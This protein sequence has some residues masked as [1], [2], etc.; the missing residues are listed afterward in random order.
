MTRTRF[1]HG[2]ILLG[3]SAILAGC[4]TMSSARSATSRHPPVRAASPTPSRSAP[5]R[6]G[7]PSPSIATTAELPPF[8]T[9]QMITPQ[10]GWVRTTRFNTAGVAVGSTLWR[11]TDGAKTWRR[12]LRA[13]GTV[14]TWVAPTSASAWI[15]RQTQ[16]GHRF[17]VWTTADGGAHWQ[18]VTRSIPWSGSVVTAFLTVS[19]AG[20]ASL[21]ASGPVGTQTGPQ[22]LWLLTDNTVAATPVYTSTNTQFSAASWA[23]PTVGWMIASS[24]LIN[25]T[26]A[27]LFRSPDGGRQWTPVPLPVPARLPSA[28]NGHPQDIP[29]L[30]LNAPPTFLTPTDGYLIASVTDGPVQGPLITSPVLYQ[31]TN[32]ET[33]SPVWLGAPNQSLTQLQWVDPQHAWVMLTSD[34]G[35]QE[36][37]ATSAT[38]GRSWVAASALPDATARPTDDLLA[39]SATAAIVYAVGPHDAL[40]VYH[41][42]DGGRTWQV[43]R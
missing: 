37:I 38:G 17:Q 41:T 15:V 18:V 1:R 2:I 14:L 22:A 43:G 31:T 4:G 6:P 36:T 35:A 30:S 21:L 29:F 26:A 10:T 3:A 25:D 19:A 24:A 23:T 5:I 11:T 33:W 16:A 27:V 39:L 40:Q 12:V 9:V 42:T 28:A 7:S 8:N 32:D 13:S 20:M 34:N